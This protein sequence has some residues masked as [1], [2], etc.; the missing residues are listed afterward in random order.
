MST[1]STVRGYCETAYL[2]EVP[3]CGG[4]SL[5]G[6]PAQMTARIDSSRTRGAQF[7]GRNPEKRAKAAQ[8]SGFSNNGLRVVGAEFDATSFDTSTRGAQAEAAIDESRTRGASFRAGVFSHRLYGGY[9]AD[10]PYLTD[11][12]YLGSLVRVVVPAQ[13]TANTFVSKKLG[14]QFQGRIDESDA[15]AAQVRQ[16]VF[17]DK[18]K[19]AQ[20]RARIDGSRARGAQFSALNTNGRKVR[21]ASFRWGRYSHKECTGG[22]GYLGNE[23]YL[24]NYPYLAPI[25]CVPIPAQFEATRVK[26]IAAQVRVVLYNVDNLRILCDFPSRG[27]DGINWTADSTA[28]SSTNAF[29]ANNLNTDIVEQV[30][31]SGSTTTASL[32]CDTEVSQGVFMD[33]LAL[34]NHNLSRSATVLLDASNTSGFTSGVETIELT[35]EDRNIY[36]V[37]PTLPITSYRYWRFRISDPGNADGFLQIGTIVFGAAI[38]FSGECFVDR[39]TFGQRH[40]V[41]R[42]FT[43]GHTNVSNDRGKKRYLQLEFRSL[44]FGKQNFRNLR[45]LF[46]TYGITHKCLYI[47]TPETASRFAV[48]GKLSEIPSESHNYKTATSDL[49]DL[50]MNIDEAL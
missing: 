12:P 15:R 2:S 9:L 13:F 31:R 41:D 7:L 25:F 40:F 10:E 28:S 19:A 48:F 45:N 44:N 49:V 37:S 39:V 22:G 18:A 29:S 46:T 5:S 21:G 8:F 34:L 38:I 17:D 35:V 14:A 30:W 6:M 47:P 50:T 11:Y 33:T 24:Q 4:L 42:I 1:F 43:E 20:F 32:V 16:Q 3:Y 36:F 23:P 27:L 26:V